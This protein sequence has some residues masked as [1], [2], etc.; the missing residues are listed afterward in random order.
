MALRAV[1]VGA[2]IGGAAA[3]LALVRA[4]IDVQV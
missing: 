4:G 1:V 2:G 3:A